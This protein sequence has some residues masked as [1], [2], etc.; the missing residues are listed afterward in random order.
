LGLSFGI[1][2]KASAANSF[3]RPK[4]YQFLHQNNE[5]KLET[6]FR[7]QQ[8]PLHYKEKRQWQR[9]YIRHLLILINHYSGRKNPD[10]SE[11]RI[12]LFM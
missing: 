6:H 7:Q 9:Q 3:G 4:Q 11:L 1:N 2:S 10:N 5:I 8:E 12:E